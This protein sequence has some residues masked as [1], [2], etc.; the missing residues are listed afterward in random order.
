M[1]DITDSTIEKILIYY[2]CNEYMVLPLYYFNTIVKKLPNLIII[3][4][5]CKID[6]TNKQIAI[7]GWETFSYEFKLNLMKAK[8][9]I[10]FSDKLKPSLIFQKNIIKNNIICCI[11]LD[12]NTYNNTICCGQP[13]H[14]KCYTQWKNTC[15]FCRHKD[16]S[17]E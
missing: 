13:L 14:L 5:D 11:C 3:K 12:E 17:I 9:K 7:K 16:Y 4:N 15:P 2:F 10:I 1:S 6:L 8:K